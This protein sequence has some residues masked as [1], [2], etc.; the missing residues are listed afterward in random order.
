[1]PRT[2]GP[3][4]ASRCPTPTWSRSGCAPK[5]TS[6]STS[7]RSDA[8]RG[9]RRS[10]RPTWSMPG[11]RPKGSLEHLSQQEIAKLLDSGQGGLYP[12]FRKCALAVLSSGSDIDD[13]RAIFEKYKDFDLRIV[14]RAWGIKLEIKNAPAAAFVDGEMIRGLEGPSVR[15]AA[16]RG[17][18]LER[19]HGERPLRSD[20]LVEHH[21]RRVPHPAQR[22]GARAADAAESRGV[23]GR[24]FHP[25][26]RVRLHQESRL[27]AR[28][29]RPR[30]VHGLRS[31]R[32]EGPDEGRDHRPFQAAHR[33]R[34]LP[35]HHRA[36]HHR[37][38][39]AES[40]RQP[41]GDHA[42]HREAP[43]GVRAPG[44]RHR[45]F[46]RAARA[47]RRRSCTCSASCSIRR[48][49]TCRSRWSS[50][51]P[52]DSEDYFRADPRLHRR[53][54]RARARS[55]AI[56]SSST[57]RPGW[58]ARWCRASRRSAIT[59]AARAIPTASTGCSTFR[60]SSSCPSR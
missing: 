7:I 57:I 5:T 36:R 43:G 3:T 20:V 12:L 31:R 41:A 50:P 42:G 59:A 14:R 4:A 13:A 6:R 27:R 35:R 8:S 40:H 56:R 46:S 29:A 15:G 11:S 54:A 48:T 38:R 30:R 60:S 23:L 34:P 16:R 51:G 9:N 55:R 28:P 37:R 44:P 39:A 22:A 53:D 24:A 10:Y 47:R 21:Q 52:A 2:T 18:H 32:D 17:V 26:G 1:M 58:R 49:A 45:R 33:Q 25:P 19:D